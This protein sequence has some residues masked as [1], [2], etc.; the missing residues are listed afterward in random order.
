MRRLKHIALFLC[1]LPSVV[2]YGQVDLDRAVIGSIGGSQT[3]SGN[4]QIEFTAGEAVITTVSSSDLTLTQGFHQGGTS[5]GAIFFSVETVPTTCPTSSDGAARIINLVGCE[6]PYEFVWSNGVT[7][8]DSLS[9]LLPGLYFVTVI[10]PGCET[11]LEFSI[12]PGPA[13]NC[14]LRFFNAFTPDGDGKSDLWTIENIEL[15]EYTSNKVE[16]FNRWGQTV[17]KASNYD[18][19]GVVWN[20]DSESG[21]KLP[22]GTYFYVVETA[23]LTFTG[24][25]E[26]I[27]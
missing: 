24:Y 16:V 14:A 6:P 20:G 13:E 22:S 19:L 3:I 17:F 12:S 21:E 2:A 1:I 18:N 11:T 8:V 26:M 15:P 27:R 7:G 4:Q 9:R 5:S 23:G 10:S 25:I